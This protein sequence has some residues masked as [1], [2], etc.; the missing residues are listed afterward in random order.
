MKCVVENGL[1]N[2]NKMHDLCATSVEMANS[3]NSSFVVMIFFIITMLLLGTATA[4]RFPSR[5][6]LERMPAFLVNFLYIYIYNIFSISYQR[7]HRNWIFVVSPFD[8]AN[9]NQKNNFF[10]FFL[11][12]F[13]RLFAYRVFIRLCAKSYTQN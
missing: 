12:V 4:A 9:W 6:I 8:Q 2:L 1:Y 7:C 13:N 11:S 10:F 5:I 3:K